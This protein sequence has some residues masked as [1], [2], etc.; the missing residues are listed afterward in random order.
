MVAANYPFITA[1]DCANSKCFNNVS[2]IQD[3]S[4][5]VN[6][7]IRIFV[8]NRHNCEKIIFED[9]INRI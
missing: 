7:K 6:S 9:Q 2:S 8:I 4:I 1:N 5:Q 3:N